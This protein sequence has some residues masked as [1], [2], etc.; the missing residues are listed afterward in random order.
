MLKR[1][2]MHSNALFY[3]YIFTK[4]FISLYNVKTNYIQAIKLH[5]YYAI[6]CTSYNVRILYI[7]CP[8]YLTQGDTEV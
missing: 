1:I 6:E 2:L 4:T 5:N 8:F 7:I 3:Y